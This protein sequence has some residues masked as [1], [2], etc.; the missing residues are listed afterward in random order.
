M[1]DAVGRRAVGD[2]RAG[3]QHC[4]CESEV[5]ILCVHKNLLLSLDKQPAKCKDYLSCCMPLRFSL[6]P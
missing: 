6:E 1:M 4:M 3:V 2:V 5:S